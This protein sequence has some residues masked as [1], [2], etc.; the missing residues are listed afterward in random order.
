ML[1]LRAVPETLVDG[2]DIFA[3]LGKSL[4]AETLYRSVFCE[5][6]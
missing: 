5:L 3:E 4:A 6:G 1:Y 2:V